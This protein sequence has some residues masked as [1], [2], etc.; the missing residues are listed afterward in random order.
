MLKGEHYCISRG[1]IMAHE[2]IG[3]SVRVAESTDRAR[4]GI[5][6]RVVDETKNVFVIENE[7][8]EV[9]VPKAEAVFEFGFGDEK[10]FVKGKKILYSPEQRTKALWRSV[11][12]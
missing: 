10:V 5:T 2:M 6:G 3:L 8:R 1:N 11:N 7:G 4:L 9:K 12:G